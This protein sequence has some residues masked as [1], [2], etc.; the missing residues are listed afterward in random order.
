[1][2]NIFTKIFGS[3]NDRV[4]KAMMQH[5]NVANNFEEELSQKSDD[6]F[7]ELKSELKEKYEA[8]K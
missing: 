4:I 7:K 8:N 3:S 1:M 2:L 5:I 6:Y